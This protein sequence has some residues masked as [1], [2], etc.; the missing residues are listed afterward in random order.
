MTIRNSQADS[1]I[2]SINMNTKAEI[3]YYY[4]H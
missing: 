4:K 2:M 1:L 3:V